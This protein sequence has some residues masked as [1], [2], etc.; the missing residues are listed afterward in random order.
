MR[1]VVL[2]RSGRRHLWA[3]ADRRACR[4]EAPQ[5]LAVKLQRTVLFF[6]LTE[7]PQQ[8]PGD[9]VYDAVIGGIEAF[10]LLTL[11]V[12][13]DHVA[14]LPA[15]RPRG[16]PGYRSSAELNK[17]TAPQIAVDRAS[18]KSHVTTNDLI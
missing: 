14:R 12:E 3:V 16:E 13:V 17:K 6:E 10:D 8:R 9:C 5:S 15:T 11:G 7:H 2:S 4:F 18:I 1:P